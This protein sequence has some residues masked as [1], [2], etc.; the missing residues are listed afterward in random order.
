MFHLA[1]DGMAFATGV[2]SGGVEHSGLAPLAGTTISNPGLAE[3]ATLAVGAGLQMLSP[4]T[5][6]AIADG[7]VGGSLA[8]IGRRLTGYV[9]KNV[10]KLST[11]SYAGYGAGQWGYQVNGAERAAQ[12]AGARYGNVHAG[13]RGADYNAY[14]GL[15]NPRIQ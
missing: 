15:A 4:N 1:R 3:V 2:I 12:L 9:A 11:Y 13:S 10:L 8:L 14:S 7:L 5:A 6:P